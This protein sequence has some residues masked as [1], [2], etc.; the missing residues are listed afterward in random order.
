MPMT[1]HDTAVGRKYT[2]R[3][4]RQPRTCS[5]SSAATT[6]GMPIANGMASSSSA[7]VLEHSPEDR[8][9]ERRA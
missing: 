2:D 1:T 3:K 7:I 5:L 6:S 9:G 4:N 8:I